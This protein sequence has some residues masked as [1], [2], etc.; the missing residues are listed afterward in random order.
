L[1]ASYVKIEN[2][3]SPRKSA[4]LGRGGEVI[5]ET[6]QPELYKKKERSIKKISKRGDHN[7]DKKRLPG[8]AG[9]VLDGEGTEKRKRN[10]IYDA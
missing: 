9:K 10:K 5:H 4:K 2:M 8:H 6:V 1:K 7:K 3:S